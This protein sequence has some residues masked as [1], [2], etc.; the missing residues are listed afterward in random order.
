[1]I[2]IKFDLH[3]KRLRGAIAFYKEHAL[4]YPKPVLRHVMFQRLSHLPQCFENVVEKTSSGGQE[5]Y[6]MKTH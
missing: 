6:I 5:R 2:H 1:M 4:A 3:T